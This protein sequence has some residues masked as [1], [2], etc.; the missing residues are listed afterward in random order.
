MWR[1][2]VL[3]LSK[4]SFWASSDIYHMIWEWFSISYFRNWEVFL[5]TT[6]SL[7][8]LLYNHQVLSIVFSNDISN[9]FTSVHSAANLM[10][11][12][13]ISFPCSANI[14]IQLYLANRKFCTNASLKSHLLWKPLVTS[15]ADYPPQASVHSLPFSASEGMTASPELFWLL[16]SQWRCYTPPYT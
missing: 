11:L 15:S 14:P 2:Q 16:T 13:I 6:F 1:K 4:D 7:Y 12:D 3:R 10:V 8:F 5:N 9:L